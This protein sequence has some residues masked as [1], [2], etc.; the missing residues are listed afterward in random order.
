MRGAS[1]TITGSLPTRLLFFS[2]NIKKGRQGTRIIKNK[3][4]TKMMFQH[5]SWNKQPKPNWTC[6]KMPDHLKNLSPATSDIEQKKLP[7]IF[8]F[9]ALLKHHRD[10]LQS[11]SPA[12]QCSSYTSITVAK[13]GS[14]RNTNCT[15]K[16][17]I[18]GLIVYYVLNLFNP[19]EPTT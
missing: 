9:K 5:E 19:Q 8:H 13:T 16:N 1:I 14:A 7:S 4:R 18:T 17:L 15:F 10:H 6:R 2:V 11:S 12:A 3:H